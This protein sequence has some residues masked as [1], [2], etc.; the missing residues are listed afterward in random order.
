MCMECVYRMHATMYVYVCL[1]MWVCEYMCVCLRGTKTVS[2]KVRRSDFEQLGPHAEYAGNIK[3]ADNATGYLAL[4]L[5]Y[6][7]EGRRVKY[8][9]VG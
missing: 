3:T 1:H 9:Y 7:V 4:H 8:T 5:T 6:M 2:Y